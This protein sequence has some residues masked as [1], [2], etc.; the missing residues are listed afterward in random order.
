[1]VITRSRTST[2]EGYQATR[3]SSPHAAAATRRFLAVNTSTS[4][5]AGKTPRPKSLPCAHLS[6]RP[7]PAM[8]SLASIACTFRTSPP[9]SLEAR[10][11]LLLTSQCLSC[12]LHHNVRREALL[13]LSGMTMPP[14]CLPEPYDHATVQ[15]GTG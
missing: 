14:A 10:L 12:L 13:R 11:F 3:T 5:A 2:T 1:M 8:R 15:E 4:R 7:H 6:M 9:Q